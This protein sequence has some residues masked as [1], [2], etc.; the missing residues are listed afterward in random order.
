MKL[1]FNIILILWLTIWIFLFLLPWNTN[2]LLFILAT[3]ATVFDL[4]EEEFMNNKELLSFINN[5]KFIYS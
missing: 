3:N 4:H 1:V 2:L 5:L